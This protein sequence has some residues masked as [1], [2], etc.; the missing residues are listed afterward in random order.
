M[1]SHS[2]QRS[3]SGSLQCC[4]VCDY[5]LTGLP[6]AYACPECA[7]EYEPSIRVIN[8]RRINPWLRGIFAIITLALGVGAVRGG[9]LWFERSGHSDYVGVLVAVAGASIMLIAVILAFQAYRRLKRQTGKIVLTC[10]QI[11]YVDFFGNTK[12][13]IWRDTSSVTLTGSETRVSVVDRS[14]HNI[15]VVPTEFFGS[16]RKAMECVAEIRAFWYEHF[17]LRPDAPHGRIVLSDDGASNSRAMCKDEQIERCPICSYILKDLPQPPTC[18]ECGLQCGIRLLV[19]GGERARSLTE[20]IIGIGYAIIAIFA[21]TTV[22]FGKPL[23]W[24][25]AVFAATTLRKVYLAH[26]YSTTKIAMSATGFVATL[27]DRSVVRLSWDA[28]GDAGFDHYPFN[29]G[30]VVVR[31]RDG[32]RFLSIASHVFAGLPHK[33]EFVMMTRAYRSVFANSKL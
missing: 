24:I 20:P 23:T 18:P 9:F 13:A 22:G 2:D 26:R 21:G 25:F 28:F 27:A 11:V 32:V 1:P 6:E 4:P 15:F 31:R 10:A 30:R 29:S 3:S 33:Y 19:F 8:E 17:I 12:S 14:G 7:F 5:D 16:P